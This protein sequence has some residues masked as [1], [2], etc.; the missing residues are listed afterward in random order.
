MI[1]MMFELGVGGW[2][3]L[4]SSKIQT[5]AEREIKGLYITIVVMYEIQCWSYSLSYEDNKQKATS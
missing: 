4:S 2:V 5:D 1:S 3:I